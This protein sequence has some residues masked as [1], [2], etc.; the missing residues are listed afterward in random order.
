MVFW[1]IFAVLFYIDPVYAI[2][3]VSVSLPAAYLYGTW[4]GNR[5]FNKMMNGG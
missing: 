3:F 1:P 4:K 5:K 2:V